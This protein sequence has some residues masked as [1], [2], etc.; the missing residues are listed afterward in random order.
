MLD[1]ETIANCNKSFRQII[2]AYDLYA[3]GKSSKRSVKLLLK[4]CKEEIG[5]QI[6]ALRESVPLQ[7][8]MS[9]EAVVRQKL[10]TLAR[11]LQITKRVEQQAER[12]F[13]VVQADIADVKGAITERRQMLKTLQKRGVSVQS[14]VAGD[15]AVAAN[16]DSN[17][18]PDTEELS[19]PSKSPDAPATP[20]ANQHN[21]PDHDEFELRIVQLEGM[22]E[23]LTGELRTLAKTFSRYPQVM[24]ELEAA[25]TELSHNPQQLATPAGRAK[26]TALLSRMPDEMVN[27]SGTFWNSR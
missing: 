23:Q 1:E 4:L 5:K 8:P 3:V 25:I 22:P 14:R 9:D 16:N 17:A 6:I 7:E 18:T 2:Q 24:Q 21:T 12:Q 10:D 20:D 13:T 19:A 11:L 26:L 27:L 15:N